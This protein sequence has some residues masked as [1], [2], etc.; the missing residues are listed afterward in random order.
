MNIF[1]FLIVCLIPFNF[2]CT[3]NDKINEDVID[4]FNSPQEITILGYDGNAMEPFITHNG[5]YLFFNNPTINNQSADIHY[6]EFLNNATFEYR[7]LVQGV[8]T[9]EFEGAPSMDENGNFYYTSLSTY[10]QNFLSIYKG[11][12]NNGIVSNVAPIDENLTQNQMGLVDMDAVISY[13]GATLIL[14]IAV[15]SNN[16]YPDESNLIIAT[17]TNDTFIKD[18]NSDEILININSESSEYAASLSNDG[19]ELFFNRSNLPSE[20]KIM[21]ATRATINDA[22][23][24]PIEIETI[25]GGVIEGAS[26]SYNRKELYY[27]QKVN[28]VFKIFKVVRD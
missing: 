27:H 4:E 17:K 26:L 5:Q 9:N 8:N 7:G 20:F 21:K 19:L 13:N 12:F 16:N 6:A 28:G 10:Q 1:K 15:F 18:S 22:F 11:I 14:A 3:N 24:I 25:S 23:G 2:S